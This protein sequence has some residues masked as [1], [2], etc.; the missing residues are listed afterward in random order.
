MYERKILDTIR[1]MACL[2]LKY[3]DINCQKS[4]EFPFLILNSYKI[5]TLVKEIF[6]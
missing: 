2:V 1:I 6:K 4:A 3:V 5:N